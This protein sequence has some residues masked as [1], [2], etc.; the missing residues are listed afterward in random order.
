MGAMYQVDLQA[1]VA[2]VQLPPRRVGIEFLPG[3][4]SWGVEAAALDLAVTAYHHEDT[5]RFD[6]MLE[7]IVTMPCDRCLR[8]MAIPLSFSGQLVVV[9]DALRPE[10]LEGEEWCI[11]P[12]RQ[13]LDIQPYIE[14]SV[15]LSLPPRHYHGAFGDDG[16]ACDAAMLAYLDHTE[17]DPDERPLEE[18]NLK[19]LR[20]LRQTLLEH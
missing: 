8:A 16:S 6:V 20:S 15:Y 11:D 19:A 14:E 17:T 3:A 9:R 12:Q 5:Y 13:Q 10:Q 2:R 1:V 18:E 7:G 4:V